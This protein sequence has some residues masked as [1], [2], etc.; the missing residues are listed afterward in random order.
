MVEDELVVE[1][2]RVHE[3]LRA[4]LR[5]TEPDTDVLVIVTALS[6][7]L[8]RLMAAATKDNHARQ[9]MMEG[10]VSAISVHAKAYDQGLHH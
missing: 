6:Y 10:L 1:S 9:L 3:A 2:H 8:G 4:W 7:E 5:E